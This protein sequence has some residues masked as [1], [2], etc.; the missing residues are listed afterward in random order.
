MFELG[1]FAI[2]L[3]VFVARGGLCVYASTVWKLVE[4]SRATGLHGRH[5]RDT[6]EH[7]DLGLPRKNQRIIPKKHFW[8]RPKSKITSKTRVISLKSLC[9][10]PTSSHQ[11]IFRT[12]SKGFLAEPL[13]R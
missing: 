6:F 10:K 12:D 8:L 11:A 4:T 2:E 7:L 5:V 13:S 9:I 3:G 1:A